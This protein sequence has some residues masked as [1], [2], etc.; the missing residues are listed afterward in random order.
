M[1]FK[2]KF[3][4][5]DSVISYIGGFINSLIVAFDLISNLMNFLFKNLKFELFFLN[6]KII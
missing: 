6:L 3:Q 5:I 1:N 2:R 4:K